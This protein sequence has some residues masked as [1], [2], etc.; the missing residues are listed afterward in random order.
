MDKASRSSRGQCVLA[1][2]TPEQGPLKM[3]RPRS[4]GDALQENC[5]RPQTRQGLPPPPP[6]SV[7]GFAV[8]LVLGG[9]PG[10]DKDAF[11]LFSL[12]LAD[13]GV[14]CIRPCIQAS[15]IFLVVPLGNLRLAS[16]PP[17]SSPAGL[18]ALPGYHLTL[19][20][21]CSW[22]LFHPELL[23]GP[24][25][26]DDRHSPPSPR[27]QKV[28]GWVRGG[29]T[30]P[31]Q[32]PDLAAWLGDWSC[33]RP[34]HITLPREKQLCFCLRRAAS[35]G[36]I[37]SKGSQDQQKGVFGRLFPVERLKSISGC[38]PGAGA[39]AQ[40]SR[41]MVVFL[42]VCLTSVIPQELGHVDIAFFLRTLCIDPIA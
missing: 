36:V 11:V 40:I 9:V 29:C 1:Q 32:P 35:F 31:L 6:L 41:L 38:V 22:D 3:R 19:S 26:S 24:F 20:A 14:P 21:L 23:P 4:I 30:P 7:L 17:S 8:R 10:C 16:W 5:G 27:T 28:G 39:E 15:G 13:S 42:R 33:W 18:P 2:R 25:D 37:D 34:D 12:S